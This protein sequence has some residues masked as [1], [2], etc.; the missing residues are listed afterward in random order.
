[1]EPANAYYDSHRMKFE[2]QSKMESLTNEEI[3]QIEADFKK[4]EEV[5]T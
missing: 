5:I 3:D 2:K 1:M 4:N